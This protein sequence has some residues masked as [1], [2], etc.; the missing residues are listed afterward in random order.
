MDPGK[1]AGRLAEE[2]AR[3]LD[4][5]VAG[6]DLVLDGAKVYYAMEVNHSPGFQGLEEAT[7][8]DVAGLLVDH[9]LKIAP[10]RVGKFTNSNHYYIMILLRAPTRGPW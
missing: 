5:D 3:A 1:E 6:V 8:M 10:K 7:G 2:A 9:A 4:L